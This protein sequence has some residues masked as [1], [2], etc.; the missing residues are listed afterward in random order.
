[1]GARSVSTLSQL[2]FRRADTRAGTQD[3][4]TKTM[5]MTP[6][7]AR[8]AD[9]L[10][11]GEDRT[12]WLVRLLPGYSYAW[13]PAE[14]QLAEGSRLHQLLDEL[15]RTSKPPAIGEF[16]SLAKSRVVH[17]VSHL[18]FTPPTIPTGDPGREDDQMLY[19]NPA[20]RQLLGE[21]F[22]TSE[23]VVP[24]QR[25]YLYV[26][27]W[28]S[29]PPS[30]R[31]RNRSAWRQLRDWAERYTNSDL[32]DLD[33][34]EADKRAVL[35]ILGHYR[36]K[37]PSAGDMQMPERWLSGGSTAT[38]YYIEEA[39]RLIVRERNPAAFDRWE[40]LHRA[41]EDAES[42]GDSKR[43]EELVIEAEA[44]VVAGGNCVQFCSFTEQSEPDILGQAPAAAWVA[45]AQLHDAG[46]ICVSLRFELEAGS[47]TRNL[48]AK[49]QRRAYRQAEE[50]Q[51]TSVT[52]LDRVE[53]EDTFAGAK[54]TED[55]YAVTGEPAIRRMSVLF[56]WEM[57]EADEIFS[58]FLRARY[59]LDVLPLTQRQF[60]AYQETL[61]CSPY[62]AA[63]GR[64][65]SH[66]SF[67]SLVAHSG[68]GSTSE[69]GDGRGA[70]LG[71]SHPGGSLVYI[72]P[73]AASEENT[74]PTMVVCG[75]PGSGKTFAAQWSSL[76]FS[77]MGIPVIMINP[78]GEQSLAGYAESCGGECIAIS[79][80]A[81]KPGAFD[82][83]RFADGRTI[84]EIAVEH[85][86]TGLNE[87]GDALSR[88]QTIALAE[89]LE[90]GVANQVG[91]VGTALH[92]LA[93]KGHKALAEQ[94]WAWARS[95]S[96]FALGIG[97]EPVAPLAYRNRLTLIE[98]DQSLALP[99]NVNA[100]QLSMMENSAIAAMRLLTRASIE[101]LKRSGGGVLTVD[102]AW[103][104][105]SS[106]HAAATINGLQR[107]GRSLGVF[108]LMLTQRIADVMSAEM[109]GYIS[110]AALAKMDDE[111][112]I[113]AGLK[114][115]RVEPR[116][117]LI[118]MVRTAKPSPPQPGDPARGVP[119]QPA[120][121]A[122]MI[123]RDLK[124]R[125]GVITVEPVPE[126]L[127]LMMSTNRRDIQD[128]NRYSDVTHATMGER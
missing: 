47:V 12:V 29:S 91:C 99:D 90:Q 21:V 27:L 28:P 50:E 97:F 72:N 127:R 63:P 53:N 7:V 122:K 57:T 71:V 121:P 73:F 2:A 75:D 40:K 5:V 110:R 118:E 84:V 123:F 79:N 23:I 49:G 108:L 78:K 30:R 92:Y 68:I 106:P 82:P 105:L 55:H 62:L 116:P 89:A 94:I 8:T 67:I 34:Y 44:A 81:T 111:K 24:D 119:G 33:L 64:P 126:R 76:Q 3:P 80:L 60:E 1:M 117:D 61:P 25:T 65:Y 88:E 39:D 93:P 107:K 19:R 22:E 104:F 13:E 83:F 74:P 87:R 112:E 14:T 45:D 6:W 11:V 124:G 42:R 54:A 10:Y 114:L 103:T 32:P 109:E 56:A 128:R 37:V 31:R 15:G 52:G 102:E 69:L 35:G 59:D 46:A 100:N 20:Y 125:H 85:I 36:P 95:N 98:F 120:R 18:Q 113:V 66:D 38:P 16:G 9:G 70:L 4:V 41:A 26:R 17:L 51:S 77:T 86:T 43:G 58:D 101:V 96:N 115:C 48:A